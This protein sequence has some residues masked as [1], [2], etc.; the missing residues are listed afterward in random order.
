MA[1][2]ARSDVT[3]VTKADDHT[4]TLQVTE[5]KLRMGAGEGG[6]IFRGDKKLM[7]V[8]DAE[9]KSVTEMTEA[10][11]KE[12][13]SRVEYAMTEMKKLPPGMWE[14]IKGN[15]PGGT[16]PKRTV[17]AMGVNKEING[18]ACSGYKV[19]T[20]GKEG[21]SEVWAAEPSILKIAPTDLAVFR[22]FA[23]FMAI[24]LPGLEGMA[25]WAKDLEHPKAD[26]VP[27]IPVLTIVKDASGKEVGRTELVSVAHDAID[28][29]S[30]DPPA[31]YTK[32][33]MKVGK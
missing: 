20:E 7:W 19:T 8:I 6:M 31:G 33:S 29:A 1:G 25:D 23:D 28:A 32:S 21:L 10:E 11:M 14:K 27:G 9:K 17:V 3:V 22:E 5:H 15:L 26:Q 30:F 13:A 16:L 2:A 4:Q 24:A 12:M 18:F